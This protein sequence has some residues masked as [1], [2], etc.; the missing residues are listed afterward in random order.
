MG[1]LFVAAHFCICFGALFDT[2]VLPLYQFAS[3]KKLHAHALMVA[4]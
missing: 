3:T 4:C 1:G 2:E